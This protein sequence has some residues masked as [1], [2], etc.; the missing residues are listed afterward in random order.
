M[1]AV[2]LKAL[3]TWLKS[4]LVPAYIEAQNTIFL[5]GFQYRLKGRVR[6][7]LAPQFAEKQVTG[8]VNMESHLDV[9]YLRWDDWTEGI[10]LEEF[11]SSGGQAPKQAWYSTANMFNPQ[12]L[13]LPPLRTVTTRPTDFIMSTG[14]HDRLTPHLITFKNELYGVWE[15][16]ATI[17]LRIYKYDNSGDS[18]GNTL[19][20]FTTNKPIGPVASAVGFIGGTEYFVVC[21]GEAVDGGEYAYSTDGSSWTLV[22][23]KESAH[24]TIWDDR[25]WGIDLD[26]DFWHSVDPGTEISLAS[27]HVD[28]SGLS[29][30]G[31]AALYVARTTN[32]EEAI[33]A[34]TLDGVF[35]YDIENDRWVRRL[36]IPETKYGGVGV[37]EWNGD[38]YIGSGL[39]VFRIIAVSDRDQLVQ[40][41]AIADPDGLPDV[42]RGAVTSLAAAHPYLA[43]TLSARVTGFLT[44]EASS[45]EGL[46]VVWDGKGWHVLAEETAPSTM[47]AVHYSSAYDLQRIYFSDVSTTTPDVS[48][49]LVGSEHSNPNHAGSRAYAA[50]A[51]HDTP[52]FR[53]GNDVTGIALSIQVE[54]E[55]ASANETVILSYDINRSGS[56]TAFATITSDGITEFPF[57]NATSPSGTEFRSIQFRKALARGATTTN[58]PDVRSLTFKFLKKLPERWNHFVTL[59][60]SEEM[61]G[62]APRAQWDNLRTTINKSSLVEFTMK[63]SDAAAST[64]RHWIR[65]ANREGEEETGLEYKGTCNLVLVEP[66]HLHS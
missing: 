9:S 64:R 26:G 24:V 30:S 36:A 53:V 1:L 55:G 66:Q 41:L 52:H 42:K 45:W 48:Y 7:Q 37:A 46:L 34:N 56:F 43:A 15:S 27:L 16:T 21:H 29:N 2:W 28:A 3:L 19:Q 23:S 33:H 50:A 51:T 39:N 11:F 4:K 40:E 44:Y 20:A 35:T 65:V 31:V 49:I 60:I 6:S 32:G 5:D 63:D 54:V 14:N 22:T 57:P 10:G 13:T 8:D 25:L 58:T 18:W 59:D 17:A 62:Q 12:H 47:T 61:E 38:L